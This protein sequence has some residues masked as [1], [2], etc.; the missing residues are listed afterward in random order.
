[1]IDSGSAVSIINTQ[2]S[3]RLKLRGIRDPL[4]IEWTDR[5]RKVIE[6]SMTISI[7]IAGLDNKYHTVTVRS[8]AIDLPEQS[9]SATDL[10]FLCIPDGS[11]ECYL[12]AKPQILLGLD[13]AS[14][15]A[16]DLSQTYNS[17]VL[18]RS[19]L[20]WALEGKIGDS[21]TGGAVCIN[22]SYMEEIK[23]AMTRFIEF[24]NYGLDMSR[25]IVESM[26]ITRAR[27]ILHE[28]LKHL[29]NK[30][31]APL[32]WKEGRVNMPDNYEYARRRFLGFER[33]LEKDPKLRQE[34]QGIIS[35]YMDKG[36]I[37]EVKNARETT[38]WYLPIFA[39]VGK[40]TRLVW[41]AAA[42]FK[43]CSLN[44]NLLTG[45][46][47]NEPLWDILYRF[48]EWPVAVCADISEMFHQIS[49]RE[50]DRRYQRFLWR[51][52]QGEEIRT[53]E[54]Q[55]MTFGANCSP[56]IAQF[57]KNQNAKLFKP[58]YPAAVFQI[59]KSHYVDDWVM[60]CKSEEEA[61]EIVGQVIDI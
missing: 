2:L 5:T 22:K 7:Q 16:V 57:V 25:P 18:S 19:T 58:G 59:T 55:V 27:A 56:C 40:K 23:D 52:N 8:M 13:N 31:E 53:F 11:V 34:A 49:T 39:V 35:K 4:I 36:Y 24:D 28:G 46:D 10:K 17:V 33:K 9:I 41:D 14:I 1:M 37:K 3:K 21:G 60:S 61:I 51:S 6:D 26:E 43:G 29:G 44:G 30:Y 20:G 54:M 48:R 12:N 45:P 50:Q 38:G 15:T 47:L 32:L 42:C